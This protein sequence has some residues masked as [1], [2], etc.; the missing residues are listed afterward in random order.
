MVITIYPAENSQSHLVIGI[1][2][3]QA[4]EISLARGI[5]MAIL[6]QHHGV[7]CLGR[8]RNDGFNGGFYGF[9]WIS[10]DFNGF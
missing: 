6:R 3:S 5:E 9:W 2:P 8:K 10:M 4:S 1:A 7:L